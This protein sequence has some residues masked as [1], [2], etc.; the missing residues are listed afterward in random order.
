[1]ILT[2]SP[3]PR[4]GTLTA[5]IK[6]GLKLGLSVSWRYARISLTYVIEVNETGST[7]LRYMSTPPF[8]RRIY[9]HQGFCRGCPPSEGHFQW[10]VKE[11]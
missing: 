8:V 9:G 1:M 4:V 2:L 3:I 10:D 5:R 7:I 11:H 6:A